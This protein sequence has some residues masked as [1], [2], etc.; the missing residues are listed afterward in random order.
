[1][2]ACVRVSHSVPGSYITIG[3]DLVRRGRRFPIGTCSI[4]CGCAEWRP[5]ESLATVNESSIRPSG[6]GEE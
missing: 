3:I 6:G 4:R 5:V 1:M 2:S